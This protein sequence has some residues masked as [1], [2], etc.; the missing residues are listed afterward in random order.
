MSPGCLFREQDRPERLRVR[1]DESTITAPTASPVSGL[2][3]SWS[4]T[5]AQTDDAPPPVPP[6]ARPLKAWAWPLLTGSLVA[7]TCLTL[8]IF[9]SVWLVPPYLAL[10]V[11]VLG[12]PRA[13]RL[14]TQGLADSWA[15]A[16]QTM[17][18]RRAALTLEGRL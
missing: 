18:E 16:I 6:G 12:F 1:Q 14:K 15:R 3:S 9:A 11:W 5:P 7:A 10:I 4:S 13:L 8:V 2:T 17:R